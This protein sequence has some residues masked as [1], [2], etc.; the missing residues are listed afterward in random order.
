MLMSK[1]TTWAELAHFETNDLVR[2][3]FALFHK[4]EP[5]D[6]QTWQIIAAFIQGHQ[7][8]QSAASASE[9][10]KP[11]LLY[12]GVLSLSRGLTLF[13][14]RDARE[15]KSGGHG[16]KAKLWDQTLLP[17]IQRILDI[18]AEV[19]SGTF[20]ELVHLNKADTRQAAGR[21]RLQ[22]KM[23]VGLGDVLSRTPSL[24]PLYS[25]VTGM[26]SKVEQGSVGSNSS[27]ITI[28]VALSHIDIQEATAGPNQFKNMRERLC[29]P[30][31]VERVDY[32]PS[33][34]GFNLP[35]ASY[36]LPLPAVDSP[37]SYPTVEEMNQNGS[38]WLVF[39]LEGGFQ[40]DPIERCFAIAYFLGMITRYF[41]SK[42]M[43][44]TRN[45]PGDAA[46][47]LLREAAIY[48]ENSFPELVLKLLRWPP[49][50]Q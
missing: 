5:S 41:P 18:R 28:T 34:F 1:D 33:G 6:E 22:P 4:Q 16:L 47:P 23:T 20:S 49:L 25:R 37:S 15:G 31:T 48:V 3:E 46:I 42:W 40:L 38:G 12:Y 26:P 14:N 13:R 30:P 50:H 8:F 17:G 44:L 2:R 45:M 43:G 39:P 7:Y 24:A 29:I 21:R 19:T 11:L 10:V 32:G 36:N 27:R 9:Q 35:H